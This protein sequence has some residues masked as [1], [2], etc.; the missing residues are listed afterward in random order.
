MILD[1]I[2]TG[3][4]DGHVPLLIAHADTEPVLPYAASRASFGGAEAP[5][6][7][8]TLYGASHASQCEDD[9]TPYD[10]IAEQA[11]LDVWNATLKK[12]RRAFARLDRD[13]AVAGLSSIE[14]NR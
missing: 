3:V 10:H 4:I 6:W 12:K 8:L 1:S 9:V 2:Q 14:A 5:V 11:T 7:L 13:A